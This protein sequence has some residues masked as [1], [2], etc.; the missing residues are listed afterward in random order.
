MKSYVRKDLFGLRSRNLDEQ[1]FSHVLG[2]NSMR[3]GVCDTGF[4]LFLGAQDV[5]GKQEGSRN[6][7]ISSVI[8]FLRLGITHYN[9][10]SFP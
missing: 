7:T 2:Q 1:L 5:K 6:K 4:S 10:R 9:F 3:A 8:Y